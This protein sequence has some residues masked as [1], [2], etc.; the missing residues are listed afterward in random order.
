MRDLA[1]SGVSICPF[2]NRSSVRHTLVLKRNEN[3]RLMRFSL[4]HV[5]SSFPD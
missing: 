1:V 4:S 2:V 3:R 5:D